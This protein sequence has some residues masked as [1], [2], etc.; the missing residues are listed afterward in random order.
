MKFIETEIPPVHAANLVANNGSTAYR[1]ER[2][3]N[4][5]QWNWMNIHNFIH[6]INSKKSHFQISA[7]DCLFCLGLNVLEKMNTNTFSDNN[8]GTSYERK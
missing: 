2:I 3:R 5:L 4:K 8:N 7:K 1:V 6:V